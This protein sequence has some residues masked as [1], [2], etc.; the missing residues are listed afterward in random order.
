MR[1]K[2]HIA[3]PGSPEIE[4][5]KTWHQKAYRVYCDEKPLNT[6]VR[7]NKMVNIALP[8]GS[9]H[10]IVCYLSFPVISFTPP[11]VSFDH[12]IVQTIPE[13]AK[14]YELLLSGILYFYIMFLM[15]MASI[16][17]SD[18]TNFNRILRA[19]IF[20]IVMVLYYFTQYFYYFK[21]REKFGLYVR[22]GF[23]LTNFIVLSAFYWGLIALINLTIK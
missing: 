11:M 21:F 2:F 9:S 12:R 6:L 10:N 14:N 19:L 18:V 17:N 16:W 20:I 1:Y 15:F 7:P 8:D 4:L 22:I 13:P 23:F 3:G 5:R